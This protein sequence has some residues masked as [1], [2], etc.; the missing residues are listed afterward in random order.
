ME[1]KK[2]GELYE[3]FQRGMVFLKSGDPAQAAVLLEQAK[4]FEPEKASIREALAR[5]YFNYG[6]FEQA[7]H[8]FNKTLA[9]NPGNHYAH[10]GLAMSLTKLGDANMARAH[11]KLALAMSPRNKSYER[12]AQRLG[13][14]TAKKPKHNS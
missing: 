14:H 3:L 7:K 12:A 6:Q 13:I 4:T 8:N 10:F 5:A 1:R 11:I 2:T 9:I